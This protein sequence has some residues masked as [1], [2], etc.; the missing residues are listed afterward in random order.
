MPKLPSS[1]LDEETKNS[2]SPKKPSWQSL[3][4]FFPILTWLPNY[5][6]KHLQGDIIAGLVVSIMLIPQ[7]MAYAMLAGLPPQIGLYA[8]ILPLFLYAIFGS[9]R[10]LAVGPV[11]IVSLMVATTLGQMGIAQQ[12]PE[13]VMMAI[14]LAFLSGTVLLVAG[15][16][17]LGVLSNFISHPVIAGFT[18]A[19]ALI[20]G[21]SQ[22]KHLLGISLE[23]SHFVPAIIAQA[24]SKVSEINI[25]A[26]VIAVISIAS[27]LQKNRFK[28]WL[29]RKK[30]SDLTAD[31]VS[32]AIPL[33]LVVF[34]TFFVWLF[35]LDK[36]AGLKIVGEIPQQ[37]PPLTMPNLDLT[38]IS[39]LILPAILMS[40]IG[41][42]ESLSV[43][44]SLAAKKRE[45]INPDQ[46]LIGL[47][48]A[49]L[50]S[51]FTGG[52][53]VTGGFSRSVVN[54]SAG[55][56]TQLASILTASIIAIALL[57]FAPL[58]YFLPKAI[59]ASIIVVAVAG[60]VDFEP[61]RKAWR[62]SKRDGLVFITTFL[63]VSIIGVE[64]GISLGIALS[65]AFY[66]WR[67]SQ[68]HMAIIGR[69]GESEH[70]RNQIRHDVT[71]YSDLLLIR[72]DENLYFA[73]TSYLE[74]FLLEQIAQQKSLKHL[75]L[76]MESVSSI[77][78]SALETLE[79]L[80]ILCK[81]TG[82]TVHF[83][84]VKGPVM[85]ELQRTDLITKH[86]KPGRVFLSNHEAVKTL[87]KAK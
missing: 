39:Q 38:L 34:G 74:Q 73:N 8:A 84:E 20:I 17:K 64:K 9:S 71:T 25:L 18:S 2:S 61:L 49:N 31:A 35:A 14:L 60:L 83:S 3:K 15:I 51:A 29:L 7:G 10:S 55:A 11:A 69:V 54:F 27:L 37:L 40:L 19:A 50:A 44:K 57:V 52:Y 24:A 86:L 76:S 78:S 65:L 48:T 21:F 26:L 42:V 23:R 28:K 75:I 58:L 36:T 22:F 47:G 13:Y 32:K 72:I 56:N 67:T 68:P 79:H 4:R 63:A 30:L 12:S 77:D 62:Y 41:F 45:K 80:V 81:E 70:F 85:D 6:K 46:E 66:L 43:A 59:L 33:F 53:A 82:I 16:F 1:P 5:N 87:H